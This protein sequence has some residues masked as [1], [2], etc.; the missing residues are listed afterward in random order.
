MIFRFPIIKF[1]KSWN[2][3]KNVCFSN[4]AKIWRF[5]HTRSSYLELVKYRMKLEKG[6][7]SLLCTFKFDE[8]KIA[9]S[10]FHRNLNK[11]CNCFYLSWLRAIIS[12]NYLSALGWVMGYRGV[13]VF[14]I[15]VGPHLCYVL[16][17]YLPKSC[18]RIIIS[19]LEF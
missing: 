5:L 15:L 13:G 1:V 2:C 3:L 12:A 10:T 17:F 11:S 16:S 7:L 6:V 9:L 8:Q 14:K 4:L 18:F 19:Q